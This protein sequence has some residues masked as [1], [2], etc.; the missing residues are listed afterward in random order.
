MRTSLVSSTA[1]ALIGATLLTASGWVL[2]LT[3]KPYSAPELTSLQQSG[4]PVAVHF[5][6][7]WCPTCVNQARAL[8][9]LKADA[10]L[11]E[12]TVL[13]ANYDTEKDLRKSLKV[14]SQSVFVVYKGAQEVTRIN[15]QTRAAE[16]KA[17]LVKAQ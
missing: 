10:Q 6:A 1:R 15:G 11:K 5:H 3:I 13:V 17:Q 7:D 4:K 12:V 9:E 14:R 8:D 16:I 2:A